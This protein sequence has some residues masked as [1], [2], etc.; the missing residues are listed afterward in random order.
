MFV[1]IAL[2]MYYDH[3][4]LQERGL[5]T[6]G[7]VVAVSYSKSGPNAAV[8]F[9]T[10]DGRTVQANVSNSGDETEVKVGAR[11][12][13]RYDPEDPTGRVEDAN[14]GAGPFWTVGLGGVVLLV[15]AA[16]GATRVA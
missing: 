12:Q 5:V 8:R 1:F 13:I 16:Y 10:A 6:T 4:T 14:G 9:T 11:I 3:R 7:D 2:Q 15:G